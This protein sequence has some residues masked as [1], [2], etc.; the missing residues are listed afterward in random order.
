MILQPCPA[1]VLVRMDNK[2]NRYAL[3][4]VGDVLIDNGNGGSNSYLL[5][6]A[7]SNAIFKIALSYIQI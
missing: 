4:G 7:L 5:F 6:I 3:K 1:F 2:K